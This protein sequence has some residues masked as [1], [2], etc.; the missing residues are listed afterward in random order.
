MSH[1]PP[2]SST[3]ALCIVLLCQITVQVMSVNTF[4][5]IW[6]WLPCQNRSALQ[7][8]LLHCILYFVPFCDWCWSA[9]SDLICNVRGAIERA[10]KTS[11]GSHIA[12]VQCQWRWMTAQKQP[13]L[14]LF[15]SCK[16]LPLS[17]T[18]II[19]ITTT[20][21]E[22]QVKQIL[23]HLNQHCQTIPTK[24]VFPCWSSKICSHFQYA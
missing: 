7:C 1:S 10:F 22:S 12:S 16:P 2:V 6:F 11:R 15:S 24:S 9:A 18:T 20:K 13:W 17:R 19:T 14:S 3:I 5:L 8:F 23:S 4:T 21:S